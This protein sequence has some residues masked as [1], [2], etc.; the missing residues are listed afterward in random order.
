MSFQ[1]IFQQTKMK[2]F[3]L[4]VIHKV[5]IQS[6]DKSNPL[7]QKLTFTEGREENMSLKNNLRNEPHF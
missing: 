1:Q 3:N 5:K 4:G 2:T 7:G 6:V